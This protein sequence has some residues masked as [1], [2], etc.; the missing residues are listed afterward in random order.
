MSENYVESLSDFTDS[1]DEWG[2]INQSKNKVKQTLQTPKLAESE[3][4]LRVE[5]KVPKHSKIKVFDTNKKDKSIKS[6]ELLKTQNKV[7]CINNNT[8]KIV[9][10][11][12]KKLI[13][14]K[15]IVNDCSNE[16]VVLID[17][18]K[19]ENEKP[20]NNLKPV[21]IINL[22]EDMQNDCEI[23]NDDLE[24]SNSTCTEN[25]I[26]KTNEQ[27]NYK[28]TE[29]AVISIDDEQIIISDDEDDVQFLS[30]TVTHKSSP[31]KIKNPCNSKTNLIKPYNSIS[32]NRRITP[33]NYNKPQV[34][35]SIIQKLSHNVTIIPANVHV[36]KG[37]EVTMVKTPPKKINS[38]FN[39]VKR[40][41]D[42]SNGHLP[43]NP[44]IIN[45]KCEIISK[46]DLNGEVKFYVR[47]PNGKE[48]P[49]PNELINQYLKQHNNQLPD[50]WLVPLPVEVAKQYGIN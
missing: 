37:I 35:S 13:N 8:N 3:K 20:P 21:E 2:A 28:Q 24:T 11:H 29:S 15:N 16:E 50:Y 27:D 42:L 36:P 33:T 48:H 10:D 18:D 41:S 25:K 7:K 49:G 19:E 4:L 23:I 9:K 43:S 34:T 30:M 40:R 17:S 5:D 38:H 32:T 44:S 6:A 45:V 14:S 39:S 12:N 1:E 26:S 46:P 31:S 47:L 22:D